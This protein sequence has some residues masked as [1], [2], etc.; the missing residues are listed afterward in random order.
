MSDYLNHTVLILIEI[1]Q[2]YSNKNYII[3]N[4]NNVKCGK[5]LIFHNSHLIKN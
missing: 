2:Y 5:F 4:Y 3:V 1:P